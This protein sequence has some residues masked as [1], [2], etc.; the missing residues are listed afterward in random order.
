MG[1]P[2]GGAQCA[3]GRGQCAGGGAQYA[4]GGARCTRDRESGDVRSEWNVVEKE[5]SRSVRY[6]RSL[7]FNCTRGDSRGR[8]LPGRG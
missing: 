5:P 6:P 3:G 7:N 8:E 1:G 2:G 4:G